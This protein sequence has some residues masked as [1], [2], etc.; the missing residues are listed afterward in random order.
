[1][2]TRPELV[3]ALQAIPVMHKEL[4]CALWTPRWI[5]LRGGECL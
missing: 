5:R 1:M 4:G 3:P 2:G